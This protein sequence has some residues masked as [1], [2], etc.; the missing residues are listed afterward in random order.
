MNRRTAVSIGGSAVVAAL[1]G[2]LSTTT[3][4]SVD[5]DPAGADGTIQVSGTGSIETE[6]DKAVASVAIEAAADDADAVVSE[7]ATRAETLRDELESGDLPVATV[8]TSN[9]SLGEHSRRNQY[10]GEH[11]FSVAIADPAAVGRVIDRAI[12]AGADSIGR[13]NFTISEERRSALY[14]DA[15]D[16][17]VA[18]AEQE[19]ALYT[20]ATEQQLGEPARIETSQTSHTPFRSQYDVAVAEDA[21]DA[22]PTQIEEGDVTVSAEVTITYEFTNG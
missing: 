17:A 14:E 8:T 16:A 6:P 5:A 22:P 1:A 15:V 13:I 12:D 21:D 18:D 20:E 3:A 4:T 19:A 9:Y 10:E 7:L 2:C 11:R